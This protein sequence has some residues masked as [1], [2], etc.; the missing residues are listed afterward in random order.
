MIGDS[1]KGVGVR[2]DGERVMYSHLST[3]ICECKSGQIMGIRKVRVVSTYTAALC[4]WEAAC[5]A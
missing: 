2:S 4:T 5:C 3:I 1:G